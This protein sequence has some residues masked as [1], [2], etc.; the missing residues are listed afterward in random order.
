MRISDIAIK[1]AGSDRVILSSIVGDDVLWFD[2]PEV[3]SNDPGI[4][5][6]FFIMALA[7]SMLRNEPL[8]VDEHLAVSKT[9]FENVGVVQK[10]FNCWNPRLSIV[11][12]PCRLLLLQL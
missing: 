2:L 3:F 11:D 10:I 5:D 7:S 1:R 6:S 12:V 8:V 9:L 4:V